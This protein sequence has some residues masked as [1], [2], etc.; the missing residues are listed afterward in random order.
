MLGLRNHG[1]YEADKEFFELFTGI[2]ATSP[3]LSREYK[4]KCDV[5]SAGIPSPI[6][7][8]DV[9]ADDRDPLFFSRKLMSRE[10]QNPRLSRWRRSR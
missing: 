3:Y 7:P 5:D 6:D 1:Y 9:V 4:R 8:A 2:L 10:R